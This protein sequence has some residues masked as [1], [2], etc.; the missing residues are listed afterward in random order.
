MLLAAPITLW[1]LGHM[2]SIGDNT[3]RQGF[4]RFEPTLWQERG[5]YQAV[6]GWFAES[7][8]VGKPLRIFHNWLNYHLFSSTSATA[9]HLGIHG[10]LFPKRTSQNPSDPKAALHSA[11]RLFLELHAAEKIVNATGRHFLFTVVPGKATIYPEYVGSGLKG[12]RS[13]FYEALI[14]ANRGHALSGF[15]GLDSALK[16][17][18][19]NGMDVYHQRSRLWSCSAAAAAAEQLLNVQQLAKPA[20]DIPSA[21]DCPPPDDDLYRIVLGEAP[22]E[23]TPLTGHAAAPHPV[24]GP[25]A[26]FFGDEYLDRL[27]PFVTQAFTSMVIIDS[28]REPAFGQNVMTRERDWIVLESAEDGLQ[29]LQLNLEALYAAAAER[30]MQGVVKQDIALEGATAVDRCALDVTPGG[31]QIRSRGAEAFFA[32]PPLS[33]STTRVFKIVKLTFSPSHQGHIT[34]RTRPGDAGTFQRTLSRESLNL[35]VPLPFDESVVIQVN[36]SEQPGVF[37]LENAEILCFYGKHLPPAAAFSKQSPAAEDL[38]SGTAI[39]SRQTSTGAPVVEPAKPAAMPPGDTLPELKLADI[40]A[41]RI[42]QRQG[43]AADIVVNGTYTGVSGSVEA[44]VVDAGTGVVV[45]PWTVVDGAPENGLYAGILRQVPQGGWY[46]LQVRSGITPWVVIKGGN[47]WGV[48]MLVACIGQSNMHE[49]FYTGHDHRPSPLLMLQRNDQWIVPGTSGNGALALGNRLVATLKIPVGL[50]DYS[51]N[52]SG[53]TAK[54]EWGKGFWRD[55]GR[56]SIYRRFLDGVGT[57][58]GSVEIVLWMQGEAD[59]ARGTV[60][61]EEYRLALERLVNDQIRSDIKNG[62]SRPQLPFL[63]IPLVKRPSGRD[64]ACQWIRGAQMDAL[65]TIDECHLAA[66]SIDLQNRGRQHLAPASYATLGIRTSQTILYLL[67]KVPYHRG[68]AIQA[69]TRSSNRIIDIAVGHRG[70]TDF[71]PRSSITGFEVLFNRQSL[72]IASVSRKDD[73]TIRIE[74]IG[75]IPNDCNVRYLYGAHPDTSN[76]VRDNTDLNLPLEPFGQ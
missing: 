63:I 58:G 24:T 16:K 37:T 29:R 27:L 60:T 36:P 33:G 51:V 6:E 23:K 76:P 28:T 8:P 72:P 30:Q 5:F 41:G 25:T 34:A 22:H 26:V 47:P 35:I 67:G 71:T 49:W 2:R 31:L 73:H 32:L 62:S 54:A 70:G 61:R 1:G 75:E 9:V 21:V 18:K 55:N 11:H 65:K 43:R 56:G 59:A 50:L 48:G 12:G 3:V 46:R 19:L 44:R 10:W 15:I 57:I 20:P 39:Q 45:V 4:P 7:L 42:F 40:N 64:I 17:A 38:F 14:D 66:L 68:P 53:L 13:R 52:G 69:V 74:M